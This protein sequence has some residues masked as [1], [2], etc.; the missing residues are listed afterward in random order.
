MHHSGTVSQLSYNGN[1]L[2]QPQWAQVL[3]FIIK[4]IMAPLEMG[5]HGDA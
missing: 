5:Y 2:W 3:Y 4:N 1:Q